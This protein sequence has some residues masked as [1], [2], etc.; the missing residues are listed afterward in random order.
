MNHRK[1][2]PYCIWQKVI[3]AWMCSYTCCCFSLQRKLN[4]IIILGWRGIKVALM[5]ALLITG[6]S[7][8]TSSHSR[9]SC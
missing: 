4:L 9:I 2:R 6:K 1:M 7:F 8:G 5:D 3:I